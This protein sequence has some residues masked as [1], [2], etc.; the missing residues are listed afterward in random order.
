MI[1]GSQMCEFSRENSMCK[2]SENGPKKVIG[3]NLLP[4]P[5][6]RAQ[7]ELEDKQGI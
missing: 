4:D 3:A 5:Y 2:F 7:T 6:L 1:L